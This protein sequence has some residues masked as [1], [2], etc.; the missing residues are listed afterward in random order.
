MASS[1]ERAAHRLTV[2]SLGIKLICI[3]SSFWFR[4][5]TA[6]LIALVPGHCLPFTC[7]N[8]STLSQATQQCLQLGNI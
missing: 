7:E 3:F 2:C 6:V 8:C 1:W 4:G 5:G